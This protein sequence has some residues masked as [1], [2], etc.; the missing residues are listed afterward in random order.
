MSDETTS[1]SVEFGFVPNE[2]D[3]SPLVP[4]GIAL[5][6]EPYIIR[7]SDILGTLQVD[8][9][10]ETQDKEKFDK[11]AT[12]PYSD[13]RATL[14]Q[15]ATLGFPNAHTLY[16]I[17]ISVP[18]MCSDGVVRNLDQ[19]ITFCSGKSIQEHVALLQVRMPDF[20]VGFVYTG[21]SI[22]LVVSQG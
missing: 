20:A 9:A 15:W 3:T 7:M 13:V 6:G 8:R 17:P 10:R 22:R 19:Y 18:P 1:P 21:N 12:L 14:L 11:I 5:P 2:N 4:V 16:E